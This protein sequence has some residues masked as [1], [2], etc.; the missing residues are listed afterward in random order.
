MKLLQN[1]LEAHIVGFQVVT[2]AGQKDARN[3]RPY[4]YLAGFRVV[5][6]KDARDE[7]PYIFGWPGYLLF[8][9]FLVEAAL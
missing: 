8:L 3:E 4:I 2:L 9:V 7:R 5:M 1:Q 6:E